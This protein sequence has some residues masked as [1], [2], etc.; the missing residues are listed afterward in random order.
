M[1]VP[2]PVA[3]LGAAVDIYPNTIPRI[4]PKTGRLT[5]PSRR[6]VLH[7]NRQSLPVRVVDTAHAGQPQ[8]G[9]RAACREGVIA[10]SSPYPINY[11]VGLH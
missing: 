5:I 9:G 11:P 2:S 3:S 4:D 8:T 7:I 6:Q 1:A 10:I